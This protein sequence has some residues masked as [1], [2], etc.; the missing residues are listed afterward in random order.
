MASTTEVPAILMQQSAGDPIPPNHEVIEIRLTELKQLFNSIDPSPF[1]ERDLDPK[2]E[3]FI[4]SWAREAPGNV[5]FALLVHLDRPAGLATEP[6]ALG[7]SIRQFFAGR[8]KAARRR[9]RQLFRV[10]RT[11]LV[12]GIAF[13]AVSLALGGLIEGVMAGRRLGELL[14]EGLLIGGWVAMWRPIEI[15]LYDWWPIRAEVK[16]FDRLSTMPLRIGYT[17]SDAEAWRRDWPAVSPPQG[18]RDSAP[19]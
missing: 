1:D 2:A 17:G 19:K 4:V 10:G 8:S 14:R 7:E 6:A 11:S 12:I 16:L 15:F 18:G 3:E 5:P 13:L 9:L